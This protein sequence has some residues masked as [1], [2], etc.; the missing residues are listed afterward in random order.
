DKRLTQEVSYLGKF[1]RPMLMELAKGKLSSEAGRRVQQ[2]IAQ[3]PDG[4]KPDAKLAAPLL[5]G[6]KGKVDAKIVNGQ[7]EIT[8]DGKPLKLENLALGQANSVEVKNVNGQVEIKINGQ[9]INFA[10][11]A[12]GSAP[13]PNPPAPNPQWLRAG[14]AISLLESFP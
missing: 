11:L 9:P 14:R 4:A 2:L 7:V 3:L 10:D 8:I 13:A 6:A 1:A 5:L 12:K